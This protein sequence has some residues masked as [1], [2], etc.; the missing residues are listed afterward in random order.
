MQEL[1]T[2]ITPTLLERQQIPPY[3]TPLYTGDY[4]F[5]VFNNNILGERSTPATGFLR[6]TAQASVTTVDASDFNV[7]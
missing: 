6:L 3:F 5:R 7:F 1:R 4:Y 2:G